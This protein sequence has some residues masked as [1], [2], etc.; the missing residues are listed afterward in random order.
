MSDDERK[1]EPADDSEQPSQEQPTESDQPAASAS[2]DNAV[3][4]A[5][6]ATKVQ[7]TALFR[8]NNANNRFQEGLIT[9]NVFDEKGKL[10]WKLGSMDQQKVTFQDARKSNY[11]QSAALPVVPGN[12]VIVELRVRMF[13]VE[14]DVVPEI[15]QV[16]FRIDAKFAVPAKGNLDVV[17]DV[18]VTEKDFTVDAKDEDSAPTVAQSMLSAEERR[19]SFIHSVNN[20]GVG[21]FSVVLWI[22]TKQIR[23][24]QPAALEVIYSG[25]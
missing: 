5:G 11:I 23:I 22:L 18:V 4:F 20:V 13:A 12:N 1:D 16:N 8:T 14:H 19:L 24:V 21:R 17:A 3:A 7:V 25:P 2:A 6:G 9:M 15:P 10:L